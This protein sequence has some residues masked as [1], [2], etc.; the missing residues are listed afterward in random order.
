[1]ET[2]ITD[3]KFQIGRW[4]N[5]VFL[6][7]ALVIIFWWIETPGGLLGKSDAIGYAVCHRIEARSFFLDDRPLPLCA[8]C[9]GMYLGAVA[10]ILFQ[11][12]FFPR[13]GGMPGWKT[14]IP[15]MLF[16]LAFG[17]DGLNSYLHLFPGMN[18]AYEPQNWLRLITGTGM[19]LS[20]A[21]MLVP[22]FN[23]SVWKKWDP[24]SIYTGWKAYL[25]LIGSGFAVACLLLIDNP[26]FRYPLA[27]I[28]AAGVILVLGLVY[29]IIWLMVFHKDNQADRWLDLVI[30]LC[31]GLLTA[32][33]Q[34]G[35]FDWLRYLLTGTWS[36]F[37]F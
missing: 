15:F 19:G 7:C 26:F 24:K 2:K 13:R 28:S 17:I 1:M 34:I 20:I 9:S 11:F 6:V 21:A 8:R 23:Q 27:L 12:I 31:A 29:A 30:P 4:K 32:F 3:H 35:V 14:G 33:V 37:K 25:G 22:A 36:G 16:V 10:G 5:I 18:G